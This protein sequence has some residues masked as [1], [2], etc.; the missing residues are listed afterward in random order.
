MPDLKGMEQ[1][2]ALETLNQIG[3]KQ[4]RITREPSPEER[5]ANVVLRQFPPPNDRVKQG[6]IVDIVVSSGEVSEGASRTVLFSYIVP[7]RPKTKKELENP[8]EP[9]EKDLSPRSV[10]LELS[11]A[12]ATQPI[13]VLK[14]GPPG[15]RISHVWR[16]VMEVAVLKIYVDEIFTETM[17]CKPPSTEFVSQ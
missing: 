3:L 13:V 7:A 8:E 11:H 16:R 2:K 6:A 14:S 12:G 4:G 9:Q 5:K 17:I 1:Q 10:R 15:T